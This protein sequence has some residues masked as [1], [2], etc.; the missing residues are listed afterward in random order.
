MTIFGSPSVEALDHIAQP[1]TRRPRD[2]SNTRPGPAVT[3]REITADK[4]LAD[5]ED[6]GATACAPV[7]SHQRGVAAHGMAGAVLP[8]AGG[9]MGRCRP[10]RGQNAVQT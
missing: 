10:P 1:P 8:T 4:V 5:L 9:W 2:A 7:R 3:G 6:V